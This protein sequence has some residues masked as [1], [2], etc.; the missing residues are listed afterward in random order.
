MMP[1]IP[2]LE[3]RREACLNYIERY[4]NA[5]PNCV[6]DEE[7]LGYCKGSLEYLPFLITL[8]KI[9]QTRIREIQNDD[10]WREID[11][12]Q[13]K[14][15]NLE[16]KEIGLGKIFPTDIKDTHYHRPDPRLVFE[17]NY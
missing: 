15:A 7:R 16:A 17:D 14:I 9:D 4:Y 6:H 3:C 13:N 12:L 5:D 8:L 2:E 11:R 10:L 1:T